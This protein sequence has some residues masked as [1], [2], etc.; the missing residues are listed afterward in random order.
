MKEVPLMNCAMTLYAQFNGV[1]K[2]GIPLGTKADTTVDGVFAYNIVILKQ[3][4]ATYFF[5]NG[6]LKCSFTAEEVGDYRAM[7]HLN[8]TASADRSGSAFEVVLQ[9][10]KIEDM[11]S[12]KYAEYLAKIAA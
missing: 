12:A 6:V 7:F 9:D 11:N 10:Q 2:Y 5:Y 3:G 1:Q 8:V 4:Q